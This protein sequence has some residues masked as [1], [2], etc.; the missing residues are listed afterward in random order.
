[1]SEKLRLMKDFYQITTAKAKREDEQT[2]NI[3]NLFGSTVA[4]ELKELLPLLRYRVKHETRNVIFKYQ[5]ESAECTNAALHENNQ[6]PQNNISFNDMNLTHISLGSPPSTPFNQDLIS[7]CPFNIRQDF[8]PSN[9]ISTC[10]RD[11]LPTRTKIKSGK[12]RL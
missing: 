6:Q 7:S 9:L 2:T 5:I 1:M 10:N 3:E 8:T 12:C 4:A 11:S